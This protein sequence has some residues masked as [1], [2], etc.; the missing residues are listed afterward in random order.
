MDLLQ[1]KIEEA[2]KKLGE[3]T[4]NAIANVD[5]KSGIFKIRE[6]NDYNLEQLAELELETE[7]L[8][9]GL[10]RGEDYEKDLS[11][12]MKIS[13]DEANS[14]VQDMN[15]FVFKKIKN[16]LIR[17]T[18]RKRAIHTGKEPLIETRR[19]VIPPKIAEKPEPMENLRMDNK[20]KQV[21]ASAGITMPQGNLV[22][23]NAPIN[24][25]SKEKR[26]DM[27]ENIENPD[28]II[29][30]TLKTE[31]PKTASIVHPILSEKML[32][33]V[34]TPKIETQY[35]LSNLSKTTSADTK[36]NN[37]S[38]GEPVNIKTYEKGADPYRMSPD[39]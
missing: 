26:E 34:Q 16:E 3:D 12:R 19:G 6:K 13:R 14:L 20:D 31:T 33:P 18:E 25:F 1:V 28:S 4:L 39:E 36:N 17:L 11:D 30:P 7:M 2:K 27:L 21:L 8:L 10:V 35:S 24:D 9:C 32:S 23:I 22:D 29:P 15:E 38:K 37:Q 5:W